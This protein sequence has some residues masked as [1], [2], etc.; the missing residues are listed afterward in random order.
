MGKPG[1]TLREQEVAEVSSDVVLGSRKGTQGKKSDQ[2][3]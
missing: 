1:H 2:V 3:S